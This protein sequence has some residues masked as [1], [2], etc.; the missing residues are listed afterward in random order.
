VIS[1]RGSII[2]TV[3]LL[4]VMNLMTSNA[5]AQDMRLIVRWDDLGMTQG[6]LVAFEKAFNEGVLSRLA[7]HFHR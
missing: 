7:L 6:S 4:T 3:S 5:S 2:I 1:M